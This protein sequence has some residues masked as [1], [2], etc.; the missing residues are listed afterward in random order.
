MMDVHAEATAGTP[1]TAMRA[2]V[3]QPPA[4]WTETP[5]PA[6]VLPTIVPA[7]PMLRLAL[8]TGDGFRQFR[9]FP[10]GGPDGT[11][12]WTDLEFRPIEPPEA[13]RAYGERYVLISPAAGGGDRIHASPAEPAHRLS[14]EPT[15]QTV[16]PKCRKPRGAPL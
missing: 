11:G 5:K 4:G 2:K 12:I 1:P 13:V 14:E 10:E 3:Q 6:V 8:N 15:M 7:G 16:C 9:F